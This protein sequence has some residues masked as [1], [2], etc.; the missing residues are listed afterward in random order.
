MYPC[1]CSTGRSLQPYRCSK[2]LSSFD[3]HRP[4]FD[5][6]CRDLEELMLDISRRQEYSTLTT[7]Y[8]RGEYKL[9]V[10][11]R[12][13]RHLPAG[14][15]ARQASPDG[16]APNPRSGGVGFAPTIAVYSDVSCAS[17]TPCNCR[18]RRD[19][20]RKVSPGLLSHAD[21]FL[22]ESSVCRTCLVI[23][24]PSDS[25]HHCKR[26]TGAADTVRT[27]ISRDQGRCSLSVCVPRQTGS[28]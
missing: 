5:K 4:Y 8:E 10:W 22:A 18:P 21:G 27:S 6:L 23:S 25:K 16:F 7:L 15:L 28:A 24:A 19:Y 2:T 9:I 3:F 26:L 13:V 11:D 20:Q 12:S 14:T 17:A 1:H